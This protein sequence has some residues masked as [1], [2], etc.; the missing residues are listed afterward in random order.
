MIQA[1]GTLTATDGIS[2]YIDATLNLN[3]SDPNKFAKKHVS[4][5]VFTIHEGNYRKINTIFEKDY[6]VANHSFESLQ[7]A[8][9]TDLEAA[10]PTIQFEIV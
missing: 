1:T 6:E 4:V 5:D 8:V 3:I 9:K 2:K 7:N 10:F